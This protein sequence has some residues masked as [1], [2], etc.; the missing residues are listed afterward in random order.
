MKSREVEAVAVVQVSRFEIVARIDPQ[1][2]ARLI[3]YFAQRALT[4]RHVQAT[5]VEGMMRVAIEQDGLSVHEA[6]II[7]DKMR[8]NWL[9]EEVG[10][11]CG[12]VHQLPLSESVV[13][14][15]A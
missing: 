9:V 6:G 12:N 15:A 13:D 10:L 4:P 8:C 3:N 2:V 5:Q 7:A 1:T 11:R 14:R